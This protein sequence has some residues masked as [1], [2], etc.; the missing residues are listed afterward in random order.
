[1]NLQGD[2]DTQVSRAVGEGTQDRGGTFVVFLAGLPAAVLRQRVPDEVPR[3]ILMAPNAQVPVEGGRADPRG[4]LDRLFPAR[5]GGVHRARVYQATAA[6]NAQHRQSRAFELP[7]Q[8]TDGALADITTIWQGRRDF[9]AVE[10]E[11]VDLAQPRAAQFCRHQ[12]G[13]T[14]SEVGVPG[15]T[16][17]GVGDFH[18]GLP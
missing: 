16:A 9:E 8:F 5:A 4:K 14:G 1:M 12:F 18:V 17:K 11:R 15:L 10:T 13:A 6:T 7:S 2:A 3:L